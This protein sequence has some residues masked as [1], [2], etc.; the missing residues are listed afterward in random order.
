M[1]YSFALANI[2]Q[3]IDKIA[4]SGRILI[5][6]FK[7]R[8]PQACLNVQQASFSKRC[9]FLDQLLK[10]LSS[11]DVPKLSHSL[12]QTHKLTVPS[13]LLL[14]SL[15]GQYQTLQKW[16]KACRPTTVMNKLVRLNHSASSLQSK[17]PSRLNWWNFEPL[18]SPQPIQM[19]L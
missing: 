11:L 16:L 3:V 1:K 10:N 13:C 2:N 15:R 19:V 4:P 12:M 6:G 14:R 5:T 8:S 9:G 18:S 7:G 17:P